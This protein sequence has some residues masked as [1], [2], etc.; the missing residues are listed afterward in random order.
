MKNLM[1]E[2]KIELTKLDIPYEENENDGSIVVP[3]YEWMSNFA[4]VYDE[5]GHYT[6]GISKGGR[7]RSDTFHDVYTLGN[8]VSEVARFYYEEREENTP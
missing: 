4:G 1:E 8:I 2:L 6:F 7:W 3:R 5:A